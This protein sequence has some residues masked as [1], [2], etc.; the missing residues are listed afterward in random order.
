MQEIASGLDIPVFLTS[1]PN[2]DRLFI[3]E[4]AGTIRVVEGGAML[5]TPFL[6]IHDR[7]SGRTEQGLLGLAFAPDYATTGRFYVYYTDVQG[8]TRVSSFLVSSDRNHT[9]ASTE[10]VL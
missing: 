3:V 6:D 1:P 8:D 10:A 7:V 2:D 5:P 4:K 9:D